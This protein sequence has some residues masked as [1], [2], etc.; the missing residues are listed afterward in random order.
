MCP[1]SPNFTHE[2]V[3]NVPKL[4]FNVNQYKPL[5]AASALA[6][7]LTYVPASSSGLA[8]TPDSELG[9]RGSL[10]FT[11]GSWLAMRITRRRKSSRG[12]RRLEPRR[13]GANLSDGE[14]P[15]VSSVS[16]PTRC[17]TV[18]RPGQS[19]KERVSEGL[20]PRQQSRVPTRSTHLPLIGDNTLLRALLPHR[21]NDAHG[22]RA[23]RRGWRHRG[24]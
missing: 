19:G 17:A 2:C 20:M 13:G 14:E 15:L 9:P 21:G 10:K 11:M 23:T 8:A 12:T 3:P 1:T 4:S 22:F 5:P 6:V 16:A 7:L 18:R 24:R